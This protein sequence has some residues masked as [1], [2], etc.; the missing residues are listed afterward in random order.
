MAATAAGFVEERE[1]GVG[2]AI[3]QGRCQ[4]AFLGAVIF[5]GGGSPSTTN[6]IQ[7]CGCMPLRCTWR[8]ASLFISVVCGTIH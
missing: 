5:K 3:D 1:C 4:G 2:Q 7:Q 6:K 8:L